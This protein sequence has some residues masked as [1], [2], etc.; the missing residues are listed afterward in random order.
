MLLIALASCDYQDDEWSAK[1][2]AELFF[3]IKTAHDCV[4]T[5]TRCEGD[6]LQECVSAV[7]FNRWDN[8]QDC[9]ATGQVCVSVNGQGECQAP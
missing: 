2:N 5:W 9:S 7:P 3:Q 6:V 8:V 4:K 1:D